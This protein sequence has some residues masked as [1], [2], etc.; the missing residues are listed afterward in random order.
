MA[1]ALSRARGR[2]HQKRKGKAIICEKTDS[3][4]RAGKGKRRK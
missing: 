2:D 3:E 1:R 4:E